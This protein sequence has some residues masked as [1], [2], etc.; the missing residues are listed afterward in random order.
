MVPLWFVVND[1]HLQAHSSCLLHVS[2][3]FSA[4]TSVIMMI[5]GMPIEHIVHCPAPLGKANSEDGR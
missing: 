1:H 4:R 2:C 3:S 5:I